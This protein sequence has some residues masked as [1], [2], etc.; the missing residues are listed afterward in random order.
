MSRLRSIDRSDRRSRTRSPNFGARAGPATRSRTRPR[1]TITIATT[2]A[3]QHRGVWRS[4]PRLTLKKGKCPE[5]R[6]DRT[7]SSLQEVSP[8]DHPNFFRRW[9]GPFFATRSTRSRLTGSRSRR[10]TLYRHLSDVIDA[11]VEMTRESRG[12]AQAIAERLGEGEG[13]SQAMR[14]NIEMTHALISRLMV[15]LRDGA[16]EM[17][18]QELQR[19]AGALQS[20]ARA[21]RDD[22][23]TIRRAREMARDKAAEAATTEAGRLGLSTD[24]ATAI[25]LAIEGTGK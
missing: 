25:R 6:S 24:T 15:Q 18:P 1:L 3:R 2:H 9:A 23:D 17:T 10:R 22:A 7:A 12:A 21:A 16:I 8:R 14:M 11:A 19:A 13:L 20:L 4:A 5:V